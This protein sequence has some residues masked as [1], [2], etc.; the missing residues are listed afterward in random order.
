MKMSCGFAGSFGEEERLLSHDCALARRSSTA[1]TDVG[2]K[3]SACD[4]QAR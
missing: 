3:L 4:I 2:R 1:V